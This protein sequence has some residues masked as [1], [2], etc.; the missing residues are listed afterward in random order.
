MRLSAAHWKRLAD[1][2]LAARKQAYAPYSR[3]KVGAALLASDGRIIRGCNVENAS[4]GLTI[5]AERNAISTAVMDGATAL[6]AMA[7]ATP[8][9][10][11]AP[12]CGMCL[13]VL[14]EFA[15]DLPLLLISS[16]GVKQRITLSKLMPAPFRWKGAGA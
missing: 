10:T 2:A 6:C 12:P 8:G 11:P 15:V 5:C 4:Y 9:R 14:A 1:E 13:Q 3:F 16:A 7:V